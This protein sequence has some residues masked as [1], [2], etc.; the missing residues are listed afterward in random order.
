MNT[1]VV[2]GLLGLQKFRLIPGTT[3]SQSTTLLLL[4]Y[5]FSIVHH[6]AIS[7]PVP[8]VQAPACQHSFIWHV[9]WPALIFFKANL[10]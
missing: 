8:N 7:S 5:P 2:I 9:P 1:V 4:T 6:G 10:W 3:F